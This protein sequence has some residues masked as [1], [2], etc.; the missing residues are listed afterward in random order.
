MKETDSA[1]RRVFVLQVVSSCAVLLPSAGQAQSVVMVDERDPDAVRLGYVADAARVDTNKFPR[2]TAGQGCCNC[3]FFRGRATDATGACAVFGS[4]HVPR[5]GWCALF[6]SN[7]STGVCS[8][9][10]PAPA[11]TMVR[12][13]T[14][15][16]PI[17]VSLDNRAPRSVENFL[18]YV[19]SKAYDGTFFH[20]APRNFVVQGGGYTVSGTQLPHIPTRPPIVLEFSNDRPNA[21]GTVAMA[22]TSALNSA[23]SE[24]FINTVDNTT[25]LG[26]ANGGGYAVFGRVTTP[27]MV[28][29]D[30]IAALPLANLGGAFT[31]LP[32]LQLTTVGTRPQDLVY[33][34][35]AVVLPAATSDADRA[36]NYLEATYWRF[37]NP[38][39]SVSATAAAG[40]VTYYYRFYPTSNS[41]I[42]VS[43]PGNEVF[44]LVPEVGPD[45]TRFSTLADLMRA[46]A[47]A[48]Y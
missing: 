42:G 14:T 34:T 10:S 12:M 40:G 15:L 37:L 4:K 24:W 1:S 8:A 20:R 27:G 17:D 7:G 36:L 29:A 13:F 9:G 32:V 28:A 5:A 48:G 43:V 35:S 41:Y 22:R 44:Y 23:T 21:R 25:N 18:A 11:N 30:A 26:A 16:G 33:I 2:F 19:E 38:P 31:T 46:V 39:G 6:F 3:E 47:A 45:I